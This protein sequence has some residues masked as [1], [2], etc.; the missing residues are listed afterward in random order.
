MRYFQEQSQNRPFRAWKL[1][2]SSVD[3]YT[4]LAAA[5]ASGS[6]TTLQG[7]YMECSSMNIY[8]LHKCFFFIFRNSGL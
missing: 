1:F 5:V 2:I 6:V 8:T 4:H 3:K 7:V